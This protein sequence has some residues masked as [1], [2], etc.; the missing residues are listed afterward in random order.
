MYN[1][2]KLWV[3][4][5]NTNL[6]A[7]YICISLKPRSSRNV[8]SK[9]VINILSQGILAEYNSYI[10]PIKYIDIQLYFATYFHP[11]LVFSFTTALRTTS[12]KMPADL[13][14]F[15][16]FLLFSYHLPWFLLYCCSLIL[17]HSFTTAELQQSCHPIHSFFS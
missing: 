15:L 9:S 4:Y 5:A 2:V 13:S 10:N 3:N 7:M 11:F 16:S 17:S 14:L 1:G 6:F 12:I 8:V